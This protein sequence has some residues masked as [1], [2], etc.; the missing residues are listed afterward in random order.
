ML[1]LVVARIKRQWVV[2]A[3]ESQFAL[4]NEGRD[5]LGVWLGERRIGQSGTMPHRDS[6]DRC[7]RGFAGPGSGDGLGGL[8][9]DH[10]KK[11]PLRRSFLA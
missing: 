8:S 9:R 3:P 6:V 2:M 1:V 5:L 4:L 10:K 11:P 7:G